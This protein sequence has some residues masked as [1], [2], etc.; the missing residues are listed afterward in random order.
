MPER[1]RTR[2]IVL[3]LA[4]ALVATDS[5]AQLGG[6]GFGGRG[7][8]GMNRGDAATRSGGPVRPVQSEESLYD[9]A[10]YRLSLLEEDLHLQPEQR[11]AWQS[12][13]DKVR[14]YAGDLARERTR[15]TVSSS[16][17]GLQHIDHAVDIARNRLTALEEISAA[18]KALYASLSPEQKT[19][20]DTRIV[21]IVAPRPFTA[22]APGN[23]SAL[24]DLGGGPPAR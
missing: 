20:A 7:S 13:A 4:L 5:L 24:P 6:S 17:L 22:G 2:V 16:A 14:A 23:A 15:L 8:R 21:S 1:Q 10:E 9:Q 3:T 11:K 18:A 12:F 19:L